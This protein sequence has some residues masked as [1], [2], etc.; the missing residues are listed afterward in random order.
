MEILEPLRSP[1]EDESL[2][3]EGGREGVRDVPS[4][5][6]C[7]HCSGIFVCLFLKSGF[8][9]SVFITLLCFLFF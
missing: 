2:G 1:R 8:N 4:P 6:C 7:V 5:P 3:K 9:E